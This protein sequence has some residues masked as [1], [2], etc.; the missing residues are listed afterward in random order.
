MPSSF[1]DE[2]ARIHRKHLLKDAVE[3]AVLMLIV[4]VL[5][6]VLM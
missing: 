1:E 2:I 6:A 3:T 5:A 4:F